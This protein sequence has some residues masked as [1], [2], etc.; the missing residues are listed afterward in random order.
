MR[1]SDSTSPTVTKTYGRS[2][3][4][5]QQAALAE[6]IIESVYRQE[7]NISLG[8]IS[9]SKSRG[10]SENTASESALVRLII[11]RTGF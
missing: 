6:K 8:G 2:S 11:I 9:I 3:N 7:L 4:E 5:L 10:G 1:K